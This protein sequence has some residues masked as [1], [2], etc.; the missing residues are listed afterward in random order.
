VVGSIRD[1]HGAATALAAELGEMTRRSSA[2]R[3]GEDG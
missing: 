2:V 1:A 3:R